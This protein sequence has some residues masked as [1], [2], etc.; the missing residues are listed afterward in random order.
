MRNSKFFRN[1]KKYKYCF[2]YDEINKLKVFLNVIRLL[3]YKLI[4]KRFVTA[5][6]HG[7]KML[8]DLDVGMSKSLFVY[9][10]RELLDT[11]IIMNEIKNSMNVLDIG[12]NIG[13]YAIL[14]ASL[15]DNSKV[16][17]FEPDPRNME[18]LKKNV[19]INNFS[20]K[21]KLYPY[22]AA[23]KDC[24][25]EFNLAEQTNL[26]SFTRKQRDKGSVKVKCI[27]LNNFASE[28][29]IDF[30]RMD[31]E[32]YE[33]MVIAGM[34]D[35]LRTKQDLKLQIEVHPSAFNIGEF[36]FLEELNSL[37]RFGFRVKYLISA[38]EARPSRIIEMGYK[39]IKSVKEGKWS[40]G[41]YENIKM[42][43][44]LFFLDNETKIVRSILLEKKD[45]KKHKF[46]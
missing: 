45:E 38:G 39:P 41:L 11:N 20:E 18:L 9:N 3:F 44:L 4:N 37:E 5:K 36:S 40:H 14:E 32:G 19:K 29:N 8:L 26:S 23:E 12:A 42:Q 10:T 15:L 25:R 24:I 30:I 22:A 46:C 27:K 6:I 13:Y 7:N 28:K 17:A 21:I 31:I 34:L 1:Y 35:F 43:D 16:Y 33:C 2:S